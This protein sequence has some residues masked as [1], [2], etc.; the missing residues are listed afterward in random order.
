MLTA[1][2]GLPNSLDIMQILLEP[3]M[4]DVNAQNPV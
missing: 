4:A 3:G 1:K 2:A